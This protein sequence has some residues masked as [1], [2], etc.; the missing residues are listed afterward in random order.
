[1]FKTRAKN[2]KLQLTAPL[3]LWEVDAF[4]PTTKLLPSVCLEL[5]S[6]SDEEKRGGG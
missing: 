3:V 1:M 6:C 4:C 5:K 2:V